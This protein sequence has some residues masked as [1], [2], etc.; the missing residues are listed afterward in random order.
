M[1]GAQGPFGATGASDAALF[2]QVQP[3]PQLSMAG[4]G[5]FSLCSNTQRRP[6]LYSFRGGFV[7][8]GTNQPCAGRQAD[9]GGAAATSPGDWSQ[10]PRWT[11]A[12]VQSKGHRVRAGR[13]WGVMAPVPLLSPPV[14]PR[15]PLSNSE[16]RC[17]RLGRPKAAPFRLYEA[18]TPAY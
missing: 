2:L 17:T 15:R 4:L 3:S 13:A 18:V 7:G 14:I 6:S 11:G 8:L 10:E 5:T 1:V 16:L 12:K 9:A